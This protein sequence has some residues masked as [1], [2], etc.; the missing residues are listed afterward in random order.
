MRCSGTVAFVVA[1]GI[2]LLVGFGAVFTQHRSPENELPPAAVAS[3]RRLGDSL[4]WRPV[5][6]ATAYVV[7]L[8]TAIG[9][10]GFVVPGDR[11][12]FKLPDDAHLDCDHQRWLRYEVRAVNRYGQGEAA[13]LEEINRCEVPPR[14]P[15]PSGV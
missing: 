13:V 10:R 4:V 14:W 9:S 7:V 5:D 12:E 6:E 15:T 1:L 3:L 2:V 8:R 11:T